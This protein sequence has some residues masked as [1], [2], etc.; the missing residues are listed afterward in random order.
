[1]NNREGMRFE[2][3]SEN[4]DYLLSIVKNKEI[5]KKIQDCKKNKV[6]KKTYF[7]DRYFIDFQAKEVK[8][9]L[10]ELTND[11]VAR[12]IYENSEPNSLG[13][14]IEGI[15]DLFSEIYYDNNH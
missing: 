6:Y 8:E 2:L 7:V 14:Y 5:R 11:F 9:I 15:I 3:S 12:G 13:I 10:N 4:I 1:M